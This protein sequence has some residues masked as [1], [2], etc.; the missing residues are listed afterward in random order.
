MRPPRCDRPEHKQPLT[1]V[2]FSSQ[3]A[4][5]KEAVMNIVAAASRKIPDGPPPRELF[6]L[7]HP[8]AQE[9]AMQLCV[10]GSVAL[11]LLLFCGYSH[12]LLCTGSE[13]F[14]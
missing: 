1:L 8:P 9:S 12:T 3:A 2:G 5:V 6:A 13:V 10:V 7:T 4:V 14:Q 11:R